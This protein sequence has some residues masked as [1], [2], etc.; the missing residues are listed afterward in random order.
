MTVT[1]TFIG[2]QTEHHEVATLLAE[3]RVVTP[4]GPGGIGK[5]R[6]ATE[7]TAD[8]A[9]R[10]AGGVLFTELAGI[11]ERDDLGNVVAAQHGF[12][13][14]D[15]L[16]LSA[17]T[18][19]T[20]VVLDNCE[21]A[22]RQASDVATELVDEDNSITVLATSRAPAADLRRTDL[23]GRP[24]AAA[25]GRATRLHTR[26]FRLP[27]LPGK[28]DILD[29]VWGDRFVSESALTS[30]IKSVRRATGDDGRTQRI[31][32]TVHGHG[33]SFVAEVRS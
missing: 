18:S 14:L 19:P 9:D 4:V 32:R 15:A 28:N 17:A 16:R 1:A 21:S 23:R 2:R 25:A 24:A 3:H 20:L 7:L 22:L 30:R 10:F 6:L 31:I 12:G 29:A 27:A 8:A 11:S 26:G 13:S 5:T 33:Y